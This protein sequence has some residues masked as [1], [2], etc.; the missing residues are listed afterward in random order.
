MRV[1]TPL[2][3]L[4]LLL[5]ACGWLPGRE[6]VFGFPAHGDV[7]EL[8]GVLTDRTGSV[9]MVTTV[10]EVDPAPPSDRGMMTFADRPNSVMA[11]WLGGTCDDKV[12][13]LVTPDGGI[14]I[15][16]MT[17]SKPEA[18]DLVAVPRYVVIEFTRPVDP[19]RTTVRFDP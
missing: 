14:T 7:P 17:S 5:G 3:A 11:N 2:L 8:H 12:A 6:F 16:V 1:A 15:T 10:Q 13:I 4:P 9:T 19:T 18:C